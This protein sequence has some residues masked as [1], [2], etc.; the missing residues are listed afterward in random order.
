MA[1]EPIT[2]QSR[3]GL[4]RGDAVVC[5]PIGAGGGD[6]QSGGERQALTT[7]ASVI[8]HT[9]PA[10]ALLIV[11]TAEA[12]E[13]I[14]RGLPGRLRER[15][16]SSLVIEAGASQTRMAT[17]AAQA[18][19]PADLV[20]VAP[21]VWV[22]ADWLQGLRAAAR[23]DSTVASATPLSLGSGGVELE[24]ENGTALQL[25]AQ[26]DPAERLQELAAR[27]A[28]R[29]LRLRPRL[30]AAGP[31]CAYIRRETLELA[32]PLDHT[33]SLDR[34]L[35]RLSTRAIAAGMVHVAAD[36]V[37]VAGPA[38]GSSRARARDSDAPSRIE[39]QLTETFLSDEH[40]SLQR[41]IG[42]A[43][44]ALRGLSVTIDG[45]ALTSAV[46][47]TQTY[48]IELIMALARE[49]DVALRVLV[50]HDLSERAATALASVKVELLSYEQALERPGRSDVVH[51]PQP[52]FTADDL[53]LLELLGERV[54]IGQLDLI[55]YHNY[56]YHRDLDDWRAYRRTTRLAL[57]GADQVVFFSEH[58]RRD[59]LA[60]DLLPA[61]R[62]H[63]V[64]VGAE[65]LE[66]ASSPAAAPQ[67]LAVGD[68]FLL[69][70]GADYAHK[71]RPFAIELLGA[72]RELGWLGRLVLAGA[73]VPFGS[74]HE[75]ERELLARR[76]DLAKFVLDLGAVD[77]PTKQWLFAHA[78]ALVYPT[79]Y[80]GFGL[81]PLEAARADLA[82]LFAAQASLSEVAPEA[83]TLI[84]WDAQASATAV[85]PL[86]VDGPAREQHIAQL[87]A[88]SVPAWSEAS[89]QL[90]AV[91]R[92]AVE[93]PPSEAARRIWQELDRES[94]AQ[95]YHDA[96]YALEARVATG[97][98]LIDEGG[99]L[100]HAQQRGL[101]RVAA[102][103]RLGAVLLAP[104]DLLGRGAASR[105]D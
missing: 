18:S 55:A 7:V 86:L 85:L 31:G 21:G 64:S 82:C 28:K 54:V 75:R 59:A 8:E 36:E 100:N 23:S 62:T 34:A 79:L 84:A 40:G 80:E 72:L 52:V 9:D 49:P 17:A 13:S 68:P 27:V 95:R 69:C 103:G 97:L 105:R 19:A 30:A 44:M 83:A 98:P 58:A 67:G 60:E 66:S 22:A 26:D 32:G 25:D 41:A 93:A 42:I 73:R 4:K 74:S 77:E 46:G 48:M 15:T 102:R 5:I 91:Y 29:A 11:G 39:D 87:H 53:T 47:G 94:T 57:G 76:P 65:V 90:L 89:R 43:R 81:L 37:L 104:L 61:G 88:L 35:A 56:S 71:N 78:R 2:A 96:Y 16:I 70:L 3:L 20:L 51:R 63:M 33:L 101:M 6:E 45:R 1:M 50:A 92:Q 99:L 14:A 12:I 38:D 10:A 24:D